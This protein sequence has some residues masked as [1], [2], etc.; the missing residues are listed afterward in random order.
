MNRAGRWMA[1][2][3]L[4]LAVVLCVGDG[5][6]PIVQLLLAAGGSLLLAALAHVAP[7]LINARAWQML[8]PEA[9]R[10][11]S[12]LMFAAT[13]VRESVNGLLPVAR[14]GGEIAGYRVLAGG[15]NVAAAAA[16]IVDMVVC[17]FSQ[18]VF[19]LVGVGLLIGTRP[20]TPFAARLVLG[21]ALLV[22]ASIA[23][24]ILQH[25]GVAARLIGLAG[26]RLAERWP[27]IVEQS[28]RVELVEAAARGIYGHRRGMLACLGLQFLGCLAGAI[29]V[30][31]ALHFLGRTVSFADAVILE[32]IVQ[33]ISSV[34]FIVPGALGV[35]E[36]GF[37]VVGAALGIDGPTSLALAAVRRLRDLV[38]FFPGLLVW[39]WSES[40]RSSTPAAPA[41]PAAAGAPVKPPAASWHA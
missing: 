2:A 11:S 31:L 18:G 26:R 8:F 4:A 38:V 19:C 27:A 10:P 20:A 39:H 41:S 22:G 15:R 14:I 17:L 1:L 6:G 40:R 36:G 5:I 23:I 30:W 24:A 13:W 33:A 29:E 32:A 28:A 12:R 16:L 3:G 35:Q 7:M 37:L 21:V 34:A 9:L 25:S